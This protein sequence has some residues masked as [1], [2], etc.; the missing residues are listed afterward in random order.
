MKVESI[1]FDTKSNMPIVVLKSKTDNKSLPIGI[2]VFEASAIAIK[3]DGV[4]SA[5][6]LTHDL[7]KSII[8]KLKAKVSKIYINGLKDNTFHAKILLEA[9]QKKLNI[10]CRP[11]DAIALAVRTDSP[12]FVEERTIIN[13]AGK[14]DLNIFL[15]SL[16]IREFGKYKM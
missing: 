3:L 16:K 8:E 6:F 11:S 13:R 5:R 9:A 2:G 4:N 10:D 12:I 1:L 14:K 15:K 7:I